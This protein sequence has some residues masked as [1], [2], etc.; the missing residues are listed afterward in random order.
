[1][2]A[3]AQLRKA[4][5]PQ[6][7]VAATCRQC[8]FFSVC[9]GVESEYGLLDCFDLCCCK[10]GHKC[11]PSSPPDPS[12]SNGKKCNSV[13]PFKPDFPEW[14]AEI[15]GLC[16]DNLVGI[17]QDALS[18]PEYIPLIH[19]GYR[20]SRPLEW[21]VVAIETYEV[22]RLRSGQYRAIA[23][24]PEELRKAFCLAPNVKIL[25]LGTADDPP[26]ERYW[27]NRRSDDAPRQLARL[28]VLA[29]IG[30]NFSHFL[31]VPRTD[32]LFNRKRQLICLGELHQAG[33]C[34]IPH[35]SAV[36]PGDWRF[37]Q[38][39]LSKHTPINVVAVEF[40]TGNK[41]H[42]EGRKVL[43]RLA[44]LQQQ[45]GRPLHLVVIGGGQFVEYAARQFDRLT[46]VDSAPFMGAVWRHAF[47][48]RVGR[49][50]WRESFSLE[51]QPLDDL[52]YSN[53][54]AYCRWT[55]STVRSARSIQNESGGT[56][57]HPR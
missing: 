11:N 54:D 15:K 48:D 5:R 19:H 4:L 32:N 34:P 2:L 21:P 10:Q 26:L 17:G 43:D 38:Q 9:G 23:K 3:P 14:L 31:D 22:F 33:I 51:R 47:E 30:P 49:R 20:R 37:W 24:T 39:Y 27:E 42:T 36:A 35:L 18:L 56:P 46:L 12:H 16:F 41:N 45:A 50:A 13:C 7:M 6:G 55:A 57:G 44:V 29:A 25:L 28:G 53:I 8:C 52:L 1:M 40:Q